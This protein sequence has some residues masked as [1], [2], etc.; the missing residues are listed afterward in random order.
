MPNKASRS[1]SRGLKKKGNSGAHPRTPRQPLKAAGVKKV[2]LF[3][4]ASTPLDSPSLTSISSTRS[5][6]VRFGRRLIEG[7]QTLPRVIRFADG[8][9]RPASGIEHNG[10]DIDVMEVA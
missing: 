6:P 5:V 4:G 2:I 1:D 8:A 10:V 7:T 3:R 9:S